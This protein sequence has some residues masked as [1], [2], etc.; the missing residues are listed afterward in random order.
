MTANK[1]HIRMCKDIIFPLICSTI[2]RMAHD[3]QKKFRH[4]M[5]FNITLL[6][7]LNVLYFNDVDMTYEYV[8][9]L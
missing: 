3:H 2:I 5:N 1:F 9:L 6:I 7:N 8:N 4:A